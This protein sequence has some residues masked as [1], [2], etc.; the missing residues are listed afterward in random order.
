M[1]LFDFFRRPEPIRDDAALTDFIDR[2]AAFVAQKGIYEYSRARAGHYSKVLFR[3]PDFQNAVEVAR[4]RAYPLTLAMVVEVA[5]NV[6]H[7]EHP[8]QRKLGL[9]KIIALALAA[10]DRYPAP[11]ALGSNTWNALRAELERRLKLIATHPPKR[12]AHIPVPY[13][14]EYFDLMPIHEK[15]RGPDFPTLGNYLKATLVNIHDELKQRIDLQA[16]LAETV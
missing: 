1:G 15:L 9:E 11:S 12:A 5:D 4:W 6:L 2:N 16:Y 14:Q 13:A 10:F 7:L 8:E 3:E